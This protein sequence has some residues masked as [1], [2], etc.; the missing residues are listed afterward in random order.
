MADQIDTLNSAKEIT[1]SATQGNVILLTLPKGTK[2][3]KFV[4]DEP[5]FFEPLSTALDDTPGTA[6]AQFPYPAGIGQD[7]WPGMGTT[8]QT[9]L[10]EATAY[11]ISGSIASQ[12]IT[13]WPVNVL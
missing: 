11:R 12:T 10:D 3:V 4:A 7:R 2:V 8:E 9:G 5:W 13:F 1:L 6:A